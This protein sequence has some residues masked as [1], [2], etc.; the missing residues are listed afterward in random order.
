MD[1][2]TRLQR[3][4]R[5]SEENPCL[6]SVRLAQTICWRNRWR[7]RKSKPT[8]HLQIGFRHAGS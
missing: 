7:A 4:A 8:F 5:I 2:S 1:Q 6:G 3:L